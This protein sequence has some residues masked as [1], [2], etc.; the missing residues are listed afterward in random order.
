MT[1]WRRAKFPAYA[2]AQTEL[3][4]LTRPNGMHNL[5]DEPGPLAIPLEDGDL[6]FHSAVDLGVAVDEVLHELIEKTPWQQ[7]S[8]TLYGKTHLQPRL[9]AWYGDPNAPYSYSGNTYQPRAWTPLLL[10]LRDRISAISGASFNSVLLNYYRN[11]NDSMGSH[12]DDEPEL[13]DRPV[14]ASLSLGATRRL[15]FKHKTSRDLR[16]YNLDLPSGSLLLMR[17]ETQ[18]YWKHSVRKQTRPCGPRINLTFRR[19]YPL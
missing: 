5:F 9:L 16:P 2:R 15:N 13:G 17:G 8:I 6:L 11:G 14:I 7:E 4:P 1:G 12:A 10:Q 18:C 19:I 3:L